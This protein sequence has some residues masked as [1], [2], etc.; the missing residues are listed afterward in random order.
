MIYLIIGIILTILPI[1]FIRR[2]NPQ[3]TLRYA[4]YLRSSKWCKTRTKALLRDKHE[5]RHCGSKVQ[6]EVHHITYKRIYKE[7]L[8][9]LITLC[10]S[11]HM[12][13]H[14][15]LNKLK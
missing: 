7:K 3:Q 6:L 5:C 13:E 14:A 10:K 11:C 1:N 4:K 2:K 8:K 9:D 12:K 15:R